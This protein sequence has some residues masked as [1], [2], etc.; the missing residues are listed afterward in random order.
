MPRAPS[1]PLL[2]ALDAAAVGRFAGVRMAERAGDAGLV[3]L[4]DPR[5]EDGEARA[6]LGGSGERPRRVTLTRDALGLAGT[7]DSCVQS[8]GPCVHVTTLALDLA[9]DAPLRAAIAGGRPD[10]VA[11]AAAEAPAR[12]RR[13]RLVATFDAGLAGWTDAV[14]EPVAVEIGAEP[15]AAVAA[16]KGRAYGQR[17]P[18]TEGPSLAVHVRRRGERALLPRAELLDLAAFSRRDR[19]V[20]VHALEGVPTRKALVTR[21]VHASLALEAMRVHGGVLAGAARRPL[22]FRATPLRPAVRVERGADGTPEAGLPVL[23]AVWAKDDGAALAPLPAAAFFPGPFPFVWLADGALHPLADDV[24]ALAVLAMLRRPRLPVPEG[25]LGD[26]G[27]KLVR[28]SR[29]RGVALPAREAIGLSTLDVP[30][31]HVRLEGEPLAVRGELVASYAG[32]EVRLVPETPADAASVRLEDRDLD[33]EARAL[34]RV[35]VAGLVAAPPAEGSPSDDDEPAELLAT[36]ERAVAFWQEGALGLRASLDPPVEIHLT[37]RLSRV[38]VGAKVTAKVHVAVEGDWLRARLDFRADDL[39]VELAVVRQAL[40]RKD[41]WVVLDDGTI[42]RLGRAAAGLAEATE[43]LLPG[44]DEKLPPHQLGRVLAW[45]DEHGGGLDDAL[46]G[47]RKRLR[48]LGVGKAPRVAKGLRAELRPYQ[49]EALAWLELLRE[50]GAGGILADDMGLGKTVVALAYLLGEKERA[51]RAPSLVVC[52]TSV[53]YNWVNEARRFAPGLRVH[54]VHGRALDPAEVNESDLVVTT[55]ALLRRDEEALARLRFRAAILDEA[56][57]IKNPE[58]QTARAAMRLDAGLR[59]ALSGTPME[60]RPRE[61]WSLASFANPGVLGSARAFEWRYERPLG[62]DRASAVADDLRAVVRP[63]L[64]RRTKAQVLGELPP[65]VEMDRLVTLSPGDKRRYD[66]LALTLREAV[67]QD[68]AA[69]GL[70][71]STLSV[72]TA[73]TRLRQMA[74]DPRLVDP[75][76]AGEPSGKREAFLELA[77]ELVAEG[78]RVLVFSQF[79]SLLELWRKDLDRAGLRT[80]WLDGATRDREGAVRAFQEG[81][82]PLFL[83]SLKAGGSGLNLT[84]ADTV[85]HCDPWWNP[86]V[87]DQATDR[88]HRIGQSRTVTVVRLVARGTIEEKIQSLKAKKRELVRTLV[89]DDAGALAGIREADLAYLLGD[90]TDEELPPA[91]RAE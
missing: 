13:A 50:L 5:L 69:R 40:A 59:L 33:L 8:F 65:K 48:A 10:A 64:L 49:V 55:Y 26:A 35:R 66:A 4:E 11:R 85:I 16:P 45:F 39:P 68:I 77:R 52:P 14:R 84:A 36:G 24:D 38:R 25:R 56:Q 18:D 31:F 82:L 21:G 76:L 34:A 27:G 87:E 58:S 75:S 7:C 3:Y 20:L 67:A 42:A 89:P 28:A 1:P 61:L 88:A 81:D 54:L 44:G 51:K 79:V 90:A 6:V 62:T 83:V 2:A 15:L 91:L 32:R 43:E 72:F 71:A 80:G 78:R 60:N 41:R 37:P 30:S 47:L 17:Q 12:R 57:V 19:A 63:F 46:A 86:A 70:P 53:A 29:G 23:A 74:C 22:D 73:L 9:E